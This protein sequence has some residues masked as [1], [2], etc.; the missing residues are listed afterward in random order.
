M[1]RTVARDRRLMFAFIASPYESGTR[2]KPTLAALG[3]AVSTRGR[4]ASHGP[5]FYHR[6]PRSRWPWVWRILCSERAWAFRCGPSSTQRP[7][8]FPARAP[9]WSELL[10]ALEPRWPRWPE[11]ARARRACRPARPLTLLIIT[12]FAGGRG[13]SYPQPADDLRR[14]VISRSALQWSQ[15]FLRFSG[16]WTPVPPI[17]PTVMLFIVC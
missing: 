14:A 5:D 2:T 1:V 7:A 9:S 4:D 16:R 8:V 17:I 6:G 10:V 12:S 11:P 15:S 3:G 13:R